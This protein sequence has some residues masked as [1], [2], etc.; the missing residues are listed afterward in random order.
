MP[1]KRR[2]STAL[3]ARGMKKTEPATRATSARLILGPLAIDRHRHEVK[4]DGQVVRVTPREFQLLWTLAQRPGKVYRREEL[5]NLVWG[6]ETFVAPRT[7]DVHMGK[8]RQKLRT[9]DDQPDF[10][11]TI[12]GVGYRLRI[13]TQ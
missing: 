7:V 6:T 2:P 13:G 11:E 9:S 3:P 8:L 4:V 5:L 12:W 10:A 1:P